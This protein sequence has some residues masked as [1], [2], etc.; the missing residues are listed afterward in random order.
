MNIRLFAQLES[1][2]ESKLIEILTERCIEIPNFK[3]MKRSDLIDMFRRISLPQPQRRY[4]ESKQLGKK[5]SDLRINRRISVAIEQDHS[6]YQSIISSQKNSSNGS[7]CT[8]PKQSESMNSSKMEV[9]LS[10]P[11]ENGYKRKI[12]DK[13]VSS[14]AEARK[15]QKIT[16]P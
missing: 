10:N 12:S 14:Q 3:T 2:P 6:L 9:H 8:K 13:E 1:L 4:N 11:S 16:W 15:R 5:L 7:S